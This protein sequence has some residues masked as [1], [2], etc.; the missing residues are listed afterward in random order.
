MT[1]WMKPFD[2]A[3]KHR[4][5]SMGEYS[6][7]L[8]ALAD[9]KLNFVLSGQHRFHR[10]ADRRAIRRT[11]Q[12]GHHRSHHFAE[13]RPLRFRQ[14]DDNL[15]HLRRQHVRRHLRWQKFFQNN[16]FRLLAIGQIL[17]RALRVRFD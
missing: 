10:H 6:E 5:F 7:A 2:C 1:R 15:F 9:V 12:L 17:A 13:I 16:H 14:A 4:S 8:H 11:L 3:R